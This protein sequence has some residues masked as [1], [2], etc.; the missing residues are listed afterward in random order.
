MS[1]SAGCTNQPAAPTA[2]RF[3]AYTLPMIFTNFPFWIISLGIVVYLREEM[4][5]RTESLEKEKKM[6]GKLKM[7][8]GSTKGNP[9]VPP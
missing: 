4:G 7:S 2:L 8:R 3:S 6:T 1:C 5:S 9:Q